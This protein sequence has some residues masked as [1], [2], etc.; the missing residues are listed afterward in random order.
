MRILL[1]ECL[2][3]VVDI[4][5]KLLPVMPDST[6]LIARTR[7][8]IEGLHILAVPF[9]VTEQYPQGLGATVPT[10]RDLLPQ[11]TT[12]AKTAFSACDDAAILADLRGRGLSTIIVCGIESHVCVQQT[13]IDLS[14][15]GFQPVVVADCVASRQLAERDLALRRMSHEGAIVV[16]AESLLFE[17]IRISGTD[18]FKAISRLVK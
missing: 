12:Y 7:T 9:I 3:L 15:L 5:E 17:L 14:A 13:V 16:S 2:C 10:I 11:A 8:L 1:E 18:R 6:A 4:Q